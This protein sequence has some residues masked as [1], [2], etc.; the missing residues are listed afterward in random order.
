M[1]SL[2]ALRSLDARVLAVGDRLA[3]DN[4]DLCEAR[5]A[6][7]GMAVHELSQYGGGFRQ[8]AAQ[9]FGLGGGAAV[10]AV[11]PGGAAERAGVR[12]D[13]A[14]AATDGIPLSVPAPTAEEASFA[15]VEG[16]LDLLDQAFADGVAELDLVRA[17]QAL[18]VRVAAPSGCAFRFQL[19]PGNRLNA[20]ADGRY[21]QVSSALAAYAQDDAELAAI[22][23]HELAHNILLHRKRLD[24]AKVSRGLLK[25]FGRN[26]RLIRET[27]VEADRLSVYLLDR[28]GYAP[29]AGAR[30]WR[31]FGPTQ[32]YGIFAS[33]T[34]PRWRE[35]A[36]IMETEAAALAQAKLAEARPV[37]PLLA[38]TLPVLGGRSAD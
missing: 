6:V 33:P 9:A 23:A 8:A 7:A 24:A 28:A 20:G 38:R 5:G 32:G 37:P 25:V 16:L 17:G 31:R 13:D 2:L 21:V 14:L 4:A 29:D 30:F 11:T 18:R 35:R 26:A 15:G 19:T 3:I 10:L 34:H 36:E 1:E 12:A 22:L 27:E